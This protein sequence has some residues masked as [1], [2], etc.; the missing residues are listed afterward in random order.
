MFGGDFVFGVTREF[1]RGCHIPML[2]QPSDDPPHPAY[3][4]DEVAKL[5][6]NIEVIQQWK[7]PA[8]LQAAIRRV[9]DFLDRHT[10]PAPTRRAA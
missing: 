4:A 6:P 10:P 8:H 1:V 3:A 5:A 2:L 9:T 7:G